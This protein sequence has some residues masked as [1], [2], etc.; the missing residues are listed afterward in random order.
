MLSI[1]LGYLVGPPLAG[2][3]FQ[4]SSQY[5]SLFL[6][7]AAMCFAATVFAFLTAVTGSGSDKLVN[8]AMSQKQIDIDVHVDVVCNDVDS[9]FHLENGFCVDVKKPHVVPEEEKLVSEQQS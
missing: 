8:D 7:C 5:D 4:V 6:F 1:G 2:L 9:S 3:V